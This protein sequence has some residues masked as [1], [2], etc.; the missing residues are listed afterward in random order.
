MLMKLV[1]LSS[2]VSL[3]P[4]FTL[5]LFSELIA[6]FLGMAGLACSLLSRCE[7]KVAFGY[8]LRE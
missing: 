2:L 6:G 4:F 7:F 5:E 8:G 3:Q 1:L